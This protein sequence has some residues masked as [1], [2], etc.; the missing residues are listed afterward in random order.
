MQVQMRALRSFF[1]HRRL[2]RDSR[3]DIAARLA[4]AGIV[5][6][7]PMESAKLDEWVRL[8]IAGDGGT[9]PSHN[10]QPPPPS[11]RAQQGRS[12]GPRLTRW[13]ALFS[14]LVTAGLGVALGAS[15]WTPMAL[16]GGIAVV[17]VTLALLL[18]PPPEWLV[19]SPPRRLRRALRVG[20]LVGL[21]LGIPACTTSL[22]VHQANRSKHEQ[23]I[24]RAERAVEGDDT[25]EVSNLWPLIAFASE[26][27]DEHHR[28]W[29]VIALFRKRVI[30][31]Q[32]GVA[33]ER[34]G[35]FAGAATAYE[36]SQKYHDGDV[37]AAY[38][39]GRSDQRHAKFLAAAQAFD[40]SA[41]YRDSK[42]RE[43]QARKAE[44]SA[45]R[46]MIVRSRSRAALVRIQAAV[47]HGGIP[48]AEELRQAANDR[49]RAARAEIAVA[50]TLVD[51]GDWTGALSALK[52]GAHVGEMPAAAAEIRRLA[53]DLREIE[54]APDYGGDLP[55]LPNFDIPGIPFM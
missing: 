9:P 46:E 27:D 53:N 36:I 49:L 37:R 15:F 35:D 21:A 52:A 55:D 3:G 12:P 23:L 39:N 33:F 30:N 48:A 6:D 43:A 25:D 1:G 32:E 8:V 45:I 47:A 41:G 18:V 4:A 14:L 10:P 34:R 7:P 19:G 11:A 42:A 17:G 51:K 54:G 16:W 29:L 40:T 50:R 22:I 20:L 2:T 31:Y 38:A 44:A 26:D 28:R 5:A 24:D 13:V